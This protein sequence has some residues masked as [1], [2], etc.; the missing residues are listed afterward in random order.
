MAVTP[1]IEAADAT[2]TNQNVNQTNWPFS[3]PA[4]DTG[5]LI[6][7]IV[8]WDNAT[9]TN[10]VTPPTAPNGESAVAIQGPISSNSNEV[11]LQAW[12]WVATGTWS[13]TTR[14]FTA[15]AAETSRGVIIKVLA[16]E[17]DA[18]TAVGASANSASA[19][20]AESNINSPA[21]TAGSSD[22]DGRLVIAYIS[23][24]DAI[25]EP[26]SGTT[27][28]NAGS[29]SSGFDSLVVVRDAAVTNS[30]SIT[31]ITAT[32]A[33]DSWASIAF[34]VR[35]PPDGGGPTFSGRITLMGVGR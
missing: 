31:A 23:D 35:A 16:G 29:S 1:V 15:S 18:T 19:G 2:A 4:A 7:A 17:F 22:G 11:R 12:Y 25:T 5:D 34:I 26:A 28:I 21:F 27:T 30:E 33:S 8:F 13:A 3:F 32:I 10:T 24:T 20:I 14:D 9:N 6:I